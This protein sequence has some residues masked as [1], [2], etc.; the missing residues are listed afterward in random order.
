MYPNNVVYESMSE[1]MENAYKESSFSIMKFDWFYVLRFKT[2]P[3]K[4]V[5]AMMDYSISWLF[6]DVISTLWCGGIWL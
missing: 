4:F 3:T 1:L 6:I 5:E 2:F